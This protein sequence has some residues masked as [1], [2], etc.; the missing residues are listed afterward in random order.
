MPNHHKSKGSMC[1]RKSISFSVVRHMRASEGSRNGNE[2]KCVVLSWRW[3]NTVSCHHMISSVPR[4]IEEG[5]CVLE[6]FHHWMVMRLSS[7]RIAFL[8]LARSRRRA[9]DFRERM[10]LKMTKNDSKKRE[11][12]GRSFVTA[13]G[14]C[15]DEIFESNRMIIDEQHMYLSSQCKSASYTFLYEPHC[16]GSFR[17]DFTSF[18]YLHREKKQKRMLPFDSVKGTERCGHAKNGWQKKRRNPR[19]LL[20]CLLKVVLDELETASLCCSACRHH[21]HSTNMLW[22]W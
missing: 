22:W 2:K 11:A 21:H 3:W 17:L 12:M 18:V 6:S 20:L 13:H 16:A 1:A 5:E 10:E 19:S 4:P 14:S 7:T 9:W 15:S 8:L